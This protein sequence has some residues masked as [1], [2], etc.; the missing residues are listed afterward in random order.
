M[1]ANTVEN[2]SPSTIRKR[3]FDQ[4][5]K[6]KIESLLS[7]VEAQKKLIDRQ[8]IE[9]EKLKKDLGSLKSKWVVRWFT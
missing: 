5:Q 3:R 4:R 6:E 7:V 2:P 8:K 9:I 1:P